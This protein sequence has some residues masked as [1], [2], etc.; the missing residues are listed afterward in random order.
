MPDETLNLDELSVKLAQCGYDRDRGG[1][2]FAVRGGIL[3]VYPLTEELPRL[4]L[5]FGE[6]RWILFEP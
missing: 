2:Q 5:N 1:G 6:M 3:D 4:G